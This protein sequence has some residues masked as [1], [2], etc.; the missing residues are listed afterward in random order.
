MKIEKNQTDAKKY[1]TPTYYYKSAREAM[2]DVFSAMMKERGAKTLFLP[3]YIGVSPKEGSGIYD[4]VCELKKE[5]L[6]VYFYPLTESLD[7]DVNPLS[8]LIEKFG[9][10]G[11]ILLRVNYFG[12]IDPNARLIYEQ[13]KKLGGNVIEDNA[14]SFFTHFRQTSHFA[15]AAF[16][17]LH[18]QFP[19][20]DGGMLRIY[21]NSM[22][23]LSCGGDTTVSEGRNP[24]VYDLIGISEM[25]RKNYNLLLKEAENYK[26]VFIPLKNL[27]DDTVVP[28]TFPVRLLCGD[29][30]SV[31]L[32]MNEKGY[33]VTS[34]YHTLIEPLRSG[35]FTVSEELSFSILN[36]PVH[37]DVNADEYHE[38]LSLLAELCEEYK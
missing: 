38:M 9:D 12:F 36:L 15:D 35:D 20:D 14:H 5:G 25:R 13:V 2:K 3:S 22:K 23:A 34:L 29:R 26:N 4:P 21:E 17:S 37:Q 30:F 31:Y 11:F 24:W 1:L 6:K 33:G 8:A 18:K 27:N 10:G 16:F 32:K 28:Q 19:F 7:I